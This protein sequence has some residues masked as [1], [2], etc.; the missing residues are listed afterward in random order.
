MSGQYPQLSAFLLNAEQNLRLF[1]V[2]SIEFGTVGAEDTLQGYTVVLRS[3][4]QKTK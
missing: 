3:Y 1:D 2:E 4:Y